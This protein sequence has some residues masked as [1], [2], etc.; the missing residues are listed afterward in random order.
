[1]SLRDFFAS[2]MTPG[3]L[4]PE[5]NY[6]KLRR[7][8]SLTNILDQTA[9]ATHPTAQAIG[10]GQA[11]MTTGWDMGVAD[12]YQGAPVTLQDWRKDVQVGAEM[13]PGL[14]GAAEARDAVQAGQD[15]FSAFQSGN[16]GQ[17]AG[18]AGLAGLSA[19]GMVFPFVG[20]VT[21]PRRV[22]MMDRAPDGGL[23]TQPVTF[24][25]EKTDE[26]LRMKRQW[27]GKGD[28]RPG[29]QV[30]PRTV[31]EPPPDRPDLP[32]MYIG[33][34]TTD[35]W[36]DRVNHVFPD[37]NEQLEMA[38]W[39]RPGGMQQPFVDALG[40]TAPEHMAGFLIGNQ[41]IDPSGGLARSLSVREQAM[42][43]DVAFD[44]RRKRGTDD[45]ELP[46]W[47]MWRDE[48]ITRG[49]GP[50]ISDFID[51][52]RSKPTRTWM[53]DAPDGGS[54]FVVDVH[55]GR[56][57]GYLDAPFERWLARNYGE[58]AVRA[59]QRDI[60]DDKGG[61]PSAQQYETASI[62]GARITQELNE[63]QY[64]G[65]DDWTPDEVQALGWMA[66]ARL[67]SDAQDVPTAINNNTNRVS[68][69]VDFGSG[70]PLEAE[71]GDRWYGLPVERRRAIQR[72]VADWA[73]NELI[74]TLGLQGSM[75]VHADGGWAA[76]P[77]GSNTGEYVTGTSQATVE[78]LLSTPEG[79]DAFAAGYGL[80]GQQ[81]ETWA[82]R[83]TSEK[84]ATGILVDIWDQSGQMVQQGE[85]LMSL[86][87]QARQAA[88][89][90]FKGFQPLVRPDG[91]VGMRMIVDLN[92]M[93][94]KQAA[95][96]ADRV[97]EAVT[98]LQGGMLKDMPFDTD[99]E[100]N[101]GD[102]RIHQNKWTENPDGQRYYQRLT[103]L[104]GE[105][106][107]RAIRDHL[108]A[109]YR[110]RLIRALD[111]G[112]G[113][114][115]PDGGPQGPGPRQDKADWLIR[116]ANTN[117]F[118]SLAG[119]PAPTSVANIA[120]PPQTF[121]DQFQA[122]EAWKAAGGKQSG[123]KITPN[124][125][126]S[127]TLAP[128]VAEAEPQPVRPLLPGRG[129]E[130]P[131]DG[132]PSNPGPRHPDVDWGGQTDPE[133][134]PLTAKYVAGAS[135]PWGDDIGL[136]TDEIYNVGDLLLPGGIQEIDRLEAQHGVHGRLK[137]ATPA[138]DGTPDAFDWGRIEID[139]DLPEH[140]FD[141]VL[142][143]EVG[144]GLD[145]TGGLRGPVLQQ[146]SP[147]DMVP[148]SQEQRPHLWEDLLGS[149]VQFHAKWGNRADRIQ[150]YRME[151]HELLADSLAD[152]MSNP[153]DFKKQSPKVAKAIRDAVNKNPRLKNLIQF[154]AIGAI[155]PMAV[156]NALPAI[157]GT[158]E[159]EKE[160]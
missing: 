129:G 68:Y 116:G 3:G 90:L 27:D 69:E 104:V 137:P 48:P 152:Y 119:G 84:N 72:D 50:K 82:V 63:R 16:Y 111:E 74:N 109:Q 53:G 121:T 138:A 22:G 83:P 39:Y 75:R 151:N 143:H 136:T 94:P 4:L 58:D 107:A 21:P 144:H 125:D 150:K 38:R 145:Y 149:P 31:I 35:D 12:P 32:R 160:I 64:L 57:M 142:P 34:L 43:G 8:L 80:I 2:M 113:S 40:D 147:Q 17:A 134:R 61:A 76:L 141:R 78:N 20:S 6:P 36:L 135:R 156:I 10:V 128:A 127:F 28:R 103:E 158:G 126:G 91:S 55:T 67:T 87:E 132:A 42:R 54:P 65:R 115:G 1:M 85:N 19:L 7:Q 88:P 114:P 97:R 117:K 159:D 13:L 23:G 86:F 18:N 146:V 14:A 26:R 73:A 30:N 15:A 66:M 148:T 106:K 96:M 9:Q 140:V 110:E 52:A 92:G 51:S 45:Q 60:K 101:W 154:A 77:E 120:P 112:D 98:Q 59:L 131:V 102:L 122:I 37:A 24:P 130:R 155:S 44:Q 157:L 47:Q 5:A 105:D 49:I 93:K 124:G 123:L 81:T 95:E 71:L 25:P 33:P 99:V 70:S 100:M 56:D 139:A 89:D 41:R 11:P 153:A 46:L 79:A 62:Q 108:G 133:G 118:A 29:Q